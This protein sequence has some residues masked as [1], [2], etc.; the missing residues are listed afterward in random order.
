M[1][2][3]DEWQSDYSVLLVVVTVMDNYEAQ[4]KALAQVKQ[5]VRLCFSPAIVME[6]HLVFLLRVHWYLHCLQ[7]QRRTVN[8]DE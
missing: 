4:V 3:V 2:D 1:R 6:M 7:K 5:M 8:L